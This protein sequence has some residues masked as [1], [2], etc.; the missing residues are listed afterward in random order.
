MGSSA[1]PGGDLIGDLLGVDN[2]IDN[3]DQASVN[4]FKRKKKRAHRLS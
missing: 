1:I 3:L 2:N 4:Q